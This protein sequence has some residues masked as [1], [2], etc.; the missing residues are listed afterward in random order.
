M[1]DLMWQRACLTVNL[2]HHKASARGRCH[3]RTL[4][5]SLRPTR[6][7]PFSNLSGK[8]VNHVPAPYVSLRSRRTPTCTTRC[9]SGDLGR[10]APTT[11][12]TG[13][14]RSRVALSRFP[15]SDRS[16]CIGHRRIVLCRSDSA[17]GLR[18]VRAVRV[19]GRGAGSRVARLRHERVPGGDEWRLRCAGTLPAEFGS[20]RRA[21]AGCRAP[22]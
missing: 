3:F 14:I 8:L 18:G 9:T 21:S 11:S 20:T 7:G 22:R 10:W 5:K 13:C 2:D 17:C 4:G 15:S 19:A 16:F 12:R 6:S 1:L